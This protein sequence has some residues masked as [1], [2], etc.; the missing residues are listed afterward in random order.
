M[1]A[2]KWHPYTAWEDYRAGMFGLTDK[3]MDERGASVDLL[4]DPDRLHAAMMDAAT[5]WPIAAEH[6]LTD[7][8][9]NRRSWLGQAAC[10]I[11]HGATQG[12]TCSAWWELNDAQ[13]DAAN[14]AADR[15]ITW[16]ELEVI[17][18]AQTLFAG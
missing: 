7:T 12:A 1:F 17:L 3:F 8:G 10:C 4:R 13:R 18:G 6:N 14:A 9:S 11:N 2:R 15:V 5:A 16:Y